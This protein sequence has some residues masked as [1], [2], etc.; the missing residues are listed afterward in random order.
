MTESEALRAAVEAGKTRN[1]ITSWHTFRDRMPERAVTD[2][3][4]ASALRTAKLAKRETDIKFII[5]GGIDSFGD[6]LTVVIAFAWHTTI[7]TV[8]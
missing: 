1:F 4:I 8:F 3:D 6:S 7:V 5:T 2:E